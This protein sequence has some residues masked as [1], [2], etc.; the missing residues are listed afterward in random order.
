IPEINAHR[1]KKENTLVASPNCAATILLLPLAPLH[2]LYRV[3]RIVLSTYQAASGG[4]A[5]LMHTPQEET[6]NYL[7]NKPDAKRLVVSYAF[8]LFLNYSSLQ[9]SGYVEE[10]KKIEEE[11]KK[12]LE[13]EEIRLSATCVRVPVLRAHSVSANVE[14]HETISL[15]EATKA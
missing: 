13:D 2:K 9:E 6:K 15:S 7:E 5:A 12:I 1:V 8:N 11:T 3:K 4:G 10:E 14:F